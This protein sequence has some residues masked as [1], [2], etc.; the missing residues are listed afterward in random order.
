VSPERHSPSSRRHSC[1]AQQ[2]AAQLDESVGR[3]VEHGED[4]RAVVDRER[5]EALLLL[6]GCTQ[7]RGGVGDFDV[8]E[9]LGECEHVIVPHRDA[10]E[11]R[12]TP[13]GTESRRRRVVASIPDTRVHGEAGD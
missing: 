13:D 12:H 7:R 9:Q 6:E 10:R 5:D 2:H 3:V 4:L 11:H 8:V 1:I